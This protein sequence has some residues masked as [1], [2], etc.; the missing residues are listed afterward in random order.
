[1][2]DHLQMFKLKELL[3]KTEQN[4]IEIGNKPYLAPMLPPGNL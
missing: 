1:M 3:N 4:S 2:L